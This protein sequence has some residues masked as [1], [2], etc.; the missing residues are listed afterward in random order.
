M[1]VKVTIP[2]EAM[3]KV[4]AKLHLAL[5]PG[6]T[7]ESVHAKISAINWITQGWCQYYKYTSKA[8]TQ[9]CKLEHYLFWKMAHWL[10]RKFEISMPIVMQR[11]KADNMFAYQ[12]RSLTRPS[13]TKSSQYREHFFKPNPYLT[14]MQVQREELTKERRWTGYETRLGRSDLRVAVLLRDNYT[15]QN[16]GTSA[17][18]TELHADHIRPVRRFKRPVDANVVGNLQTLC[19]ACHVAKTK[20]DRQAES[21]MR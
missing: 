19:I 15:C 21:R 11:F 6:T 8:T 3:D 9:F 12:G 14:Q 1:T 17:T 13:E 20:S 18:E 4:R 5:A 2:K 10:G 16:C 7:K